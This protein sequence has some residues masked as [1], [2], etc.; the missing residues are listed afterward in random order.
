MV[1][2]S[3]SLIWK[4]RAAQTVSASFRDEA[5]NGVREQLPT[6]SRRGR[7][8]SPFYVSHRVSARRNVGS[9]GGQGNGGYLE[10]RK[11]SPT[12]LLKH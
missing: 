8:S 6:E 11:T 9:I 3:I 1:I 2:R 12:L 5:L 7:V 10:G 4:N